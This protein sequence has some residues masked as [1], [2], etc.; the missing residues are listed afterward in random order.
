MEQSMAQKVDSTQGKG[1]GAEEK[2][3]NHDNF[4]NGLLKRPEN[5][6][7]VTI[8]MAGWRPDWGN[9]GGSGFF[10]DR[11]TIESCIHNGVLDTNELD[12]KLQTAL[13]DRNLKADGIYQA[14]SHV[15]V[16]TINFEKL[17]NL[18]NTDPELYK[19]LTG[20]DGRDSDDIKVAYGKVQA[21]TNNGTGGG[22]QYYIDPETFEK[23]KAAG[24]FE[25]DPKESFSI[26]PTAGQKPISRRDITRDEYAKL[27]KAR[28]KSVE[29]KA[30]EYEAM[31]Q[32]GE[33][34]GLT[35]GEILNRF[36]NNPADNF[37]AKPDESY[38]Y[39]ERKSK[40]TDKQIKCAEEKKSN[41]PAPKIAMSR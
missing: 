33:A 14:H 13:S 5:G 24:V 8:Y 21:N 22:N 1:S 10:T 37:I 30:F 25:Y 2:Y 17:D 3:P 9:N 34:K 38:D 15:S 40:E 36:E 18:K 41:T 29:A 7:K 26:N 39:G 31:M 11:E 28:E 32:E 19:K 23:A 6:E 12:S 16:Y 20:P 27:Q 4:Q 35:R